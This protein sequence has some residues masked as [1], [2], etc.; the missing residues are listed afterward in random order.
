MHCPD[1]YESVEL[2]VHSSFW[3]YRNARTQPG[4]PLLICRTLSKWK[5]NIT[6][7]HLVAYLLGA[8]GHYRRPLWP[9]FPAGG[10]LFLGSC[11]LK[12][13]LQTSKFDESPGL[14]DW[15]NESN[16]LWWAPSVP[17]S[18]VIFCLWAQPTFSR[19]HMDMGPDLS[20]WRL[21]TE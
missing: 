11:W 1:A 17:K 5:D 21:V 3:N 19:T 7:L 15:L 6:K 2:C 14:A 10:T 9:N 16:L 20:R 12:L 4:T 13:C 18:G 8:L